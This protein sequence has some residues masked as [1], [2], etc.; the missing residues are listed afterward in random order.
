MSSFSETDEVSL[1]RGRECRFNKKVGSRKTTS[2][3]AA[4]KIE[5][6]V[7]FIE[8]APTATPHQ[9]LSSQLP[10][11]GE[12]FRCVVFILRFENCSGK[13]ISSSSLSSRTFCHIQKSQALLMPDFLFFTHHLSA[14]NLQD[15]MQYR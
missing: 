13:V 7:L 1:M 14:N 9:A 6:A 12:A 4:R 2:L 15:R 11:S 10:L 3:F 5:T 8:T